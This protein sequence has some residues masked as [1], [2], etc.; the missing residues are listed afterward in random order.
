MSQD[1][2]SSRNSKT[3]DELYHELDSLIGQFGW[4]QAMSCTVV[5]SLGNL[6]VTGGQRV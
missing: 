6:K 5:Y 2:D 1:S 4:Y 3:D